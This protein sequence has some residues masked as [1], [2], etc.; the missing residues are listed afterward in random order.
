MVRAQFIIILAMACNSSLAG[1]TASEL[2]AEITDNIAMEYAEC[3]A[4]FTIV[5]GAFERSGKLDEAR[6]FEELALEATKF[7]F[8]AA[9]KSRNESMATKVTVAR[10]E[11]NLKDMQRTIEN[12]Y[13][14]ISLL[15]NKYLTPCA[16]AMRDSMPLVERWTRK[17]QRKYEKTSGS[18]P[19]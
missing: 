11:M 7:S 17:I 15:S 6:K 8:A 4:Y 10:V 18:M 12:N 13:S 16:E 9:E 3:S 14:N 19:Q 1:P 5:S 2:A